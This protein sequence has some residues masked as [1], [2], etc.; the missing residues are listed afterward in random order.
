MSLVENKTFQSM[1]E[2][3]A[4]EGACRVVDR[5]DAS[6]R[7]RLHAHNCSVCGL[8]RTCS[9]E[10]C[11]FRGREGQDNSAGWTCY[12]CDDASALT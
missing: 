2:E 7:S 11:E 12:A 9:Q 4:A 5:R 10:P 1:L 6:T 3:L 8:L